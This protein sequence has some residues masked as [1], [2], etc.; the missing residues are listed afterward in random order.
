MAYEF[1]EQVKDKGERRILIR[2]ARG[3]FAGPPRRMAGTST[4]DGQETARWL[5]IPVDVEL[6]KNRNRRMNHRGSWIHWRIT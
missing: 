2:F 5:M 1:E 6:T 4:H 3:V